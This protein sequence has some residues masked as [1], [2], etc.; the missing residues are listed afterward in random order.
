MRGS[1]LIIAQSD[2]TH[3]WFR[4]AKQNKRNWEAIYPARDYHHLS[5]LLALLR[6]K[7]FLQQ[8]I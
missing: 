7:L 2:L 6:I 1:L 8:R 3:V 5:L 4:V